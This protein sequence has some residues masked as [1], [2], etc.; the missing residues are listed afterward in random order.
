MYPQSLLTVPAVAEMFS[1]KGSVGEAVL[2]EALLKHAGP[3]EIVGDLPA[4]WKV[5][6]RC[7]TRDLSPSNCDSSGEILSYSCV[8]VEPK[9]DI[10]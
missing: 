3:E 2:G 1:V 7:S 10:R 9:R 8:R 5:G 4:A 6:T